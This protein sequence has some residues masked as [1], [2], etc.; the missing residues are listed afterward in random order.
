VLLVLRLLD[1]LIGDFVSLDGGVV[2]SCVIVLVISDRLVMCIEC[3]LV[4]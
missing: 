3:W 4:V 2:C 1:C